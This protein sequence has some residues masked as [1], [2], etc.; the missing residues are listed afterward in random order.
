MFHD[1]WDCE[2]SA[3]KGRWYSLFAG[4]CLLNKRVR[5]AALAQVAPMRSAKM[6]QV[7]LRSSHVRSSAP[8][9]HVARMHNQNVR[10][11]TGSRQAESISTR[12]RAKNNEN[13]IAPSSSKIEKKVLCAARRETET[14]ISVL[15]SDAK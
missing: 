4:A 5:G 13:P 3:D 11:I 9:P 15:E 1:N 8:I 2:I 10:S 12:S 14:P 7:G 6:T